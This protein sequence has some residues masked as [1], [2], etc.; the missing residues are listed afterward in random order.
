MLKLCAYTLEVKQFSEYNQLKFIVP[1]GRNKH[2]YPI[3]HKIAFNFEPFSKL[4]VTSQLPWL[5]Y[6]AEDVDASDYKQ[7]C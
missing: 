5:D 3:E 2:S 6:K 7:S 1:E 4:L